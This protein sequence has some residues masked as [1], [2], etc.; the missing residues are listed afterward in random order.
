MEC[1]DENWLLLF[2]VDYEGVVGE[3]TSSI[4]MG[5]IGRNINDKGFFF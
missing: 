5:K 1:V 4:L 3:I 2:I